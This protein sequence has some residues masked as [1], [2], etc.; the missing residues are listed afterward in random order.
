MWGSG[1]CGLGKC[2]FKIFY[3]RLNIPRNTICSVTTCQDINFLTETSVTGAPSHDNPGR[4]GPCPCSWSST[5]QT[6]RAQEGRVPGPTCR[7]KSG[8]HRDLTCRRLQSYTLRLGPPP[9]DHHTCPRRPL[10]FGKGRERNDTGPT[11]VSQSRHR[12]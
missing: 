6:H 8:A 7:P 1:T 5:T 12:R 11:E 3:R 2:R 4:Q 10:S 9:T